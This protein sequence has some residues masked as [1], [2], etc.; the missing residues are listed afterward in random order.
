MEYILENTNLS[1]AERKQEDVLILV[2]K[3]VETKFKLQETLDN[4]YYKNIKKFYTKDYSRRTLP[5]PRFNIEAFMETILDLK[6]VDNKYIVYTNGDGMGSKRYSVKPK[7]KGFAISGVEMECFSCSG[8]GK[9]FLDMD[10]SYFSGNVDAAINKGVFLEEVSC[11]NCN[12]KGWV[13]VIF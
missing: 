7:G 5:E 8:S 11:Q 10:G 1:I 13:A 9:V 4:I 3:Y 12:S 2:R 6:K